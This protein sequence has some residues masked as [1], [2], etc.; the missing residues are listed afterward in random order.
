MAL[1][2]LLITV[3]TA[4]SPTTALGAQHGGRLRKAWPSA[5]PP[6]ATGPDTALQLPT[7]MPTGAWNPGQRA[8]S[9]G[10]LPRTGGALL[11]APRHLAKCLVVGFC[12]QAV[13]HSIAT[14]IK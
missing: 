2:K 3:G 9:P 4:P 13:C 11:S 1:P 6:C 8:V 12:R 7:A 14:H 10:P 5:T